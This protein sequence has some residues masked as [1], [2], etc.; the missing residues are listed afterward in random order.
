M[1]VFEQKSL[2]K[3]VIKENKDEE[4]IIL[5]IMFHSM[6]IIPNATPFVR[7]KFEQKL[8]LNRLE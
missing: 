3:Q 5:N 1:T 7:S 6:E 8:F 2:I 4:I